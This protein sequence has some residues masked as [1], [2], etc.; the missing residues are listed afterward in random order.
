MAYIFEKEY[1]V[2]YY[3]T[4]VNKR[5]LVS[6]L[7]NFFDDCAILQSEKLGVGIDF[8]NSKGFSWCLYQWDIKIVRLPVFG[9]RVW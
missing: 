9:D 2:R 4:D 3:E 1:D 6:R 5:L 8:L 7:T